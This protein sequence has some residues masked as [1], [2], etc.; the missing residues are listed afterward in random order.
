M[1]VTIDHEHLGQIT[2]TVKTPS[3]GWELARIIMVGNPDVIK[4]VEVVLR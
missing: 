1:Y 4:S 2:F 3:D